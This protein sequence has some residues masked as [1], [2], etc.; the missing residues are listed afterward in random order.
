MD[1]RRRRRQQPER[2]ATG[3][4]ELSDCFDASTAKASKTNLK[5]TAATNIVQQVSNPPTKRSD[6]NGRTHRQ[7]EQFRL[8]P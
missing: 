7:H 5:K 1:Y 4:Y 2:P 3:A 8:Q 6:A